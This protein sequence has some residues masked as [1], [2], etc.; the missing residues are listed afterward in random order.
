MLE[1]RIIEA[2]VADTGKVPFLDWLH[3]LDQIVQTRLENRIVRLRAG[4]FGD[5]K[6]VEEGVFELR[7]FF[8]P[9]YRIYF[10]QYGGCIVLLLWGGTKRMQPRDVQVAK[11][12]W[13]KFK[14]TIQ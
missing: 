6:S 14:E 5:C 12:H 7:F 11:G 3:S 1:M 9:G 2:Y 8:G 4:D 13:R 10:A